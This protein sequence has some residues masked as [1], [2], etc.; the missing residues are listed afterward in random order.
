LFSFRE[1]P[2]VIKALEQIEITPDLIICDGQGIAHPRRF[3]MA[4]HLGVLFDVPTIGCAKRR[5]VGSIQENKKIRGE[6]SPICDNNEI[7]GAALITQDNVK[8][9][10]VSIGHKISLQNACNWVL[11]M[12]PMYRIPEPIRQADHLVRMKMK[13]QQDN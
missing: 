2:P 3:G 11:K 7:I 8:P 10:F 9:V 4:S 6:Y 5:L 13:S 1:I 12:S